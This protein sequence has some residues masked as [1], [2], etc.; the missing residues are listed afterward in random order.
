MND[1]IQLGLTDV[2]ASGPAPSS[3]VN[4]EILVLGMTCGHCVASVKEE[5]S[6]I[7]GVEGVTVALNA[8][9]TSRVIVHSAQPIDDDALTAAVAEAGYT[10]VGASA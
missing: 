6:E 3:A 1:R 2:S 8:G 5:L 7:D 9:G 10:R 4:E